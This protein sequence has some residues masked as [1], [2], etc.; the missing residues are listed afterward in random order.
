MS[1]ICK[2][3]RAGDDRVMSR[4]LLLRIHLAR[5]LRRVANTAWITMCDA[6]QPRGKQAVTAAAAEQILLRPPRQWMDVQ[7]SAALMPPVLPI[8]QYVLPT[9][10]ASSFYGPFR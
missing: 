4:H 2:Q 7:L 3:N 8:R 1:R 5:T 10:F 9:K 6:G